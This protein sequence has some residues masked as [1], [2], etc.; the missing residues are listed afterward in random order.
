MKA[1]IVTKR[2]IECPGCGNPDRFS[3]EHLFDGAT[4]QFHRWP[5]GLDGCTAEV[6]G[7][8]HPNGSVE[9]E[10]VMNPARAPGFA[11]VKLRDLYLVLEEPHGR[12]EADHADYFYH[13]HQ[14]PTS[15]LKNVVEV[16]GPSGEADVH[17]MIRY[18]AGVADTEETRNALGVDGHGVSLRKVLEVFSTDGEPAPTSWPEVDEGVIPMIAEARRARRDKS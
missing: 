12:I 6:S 13:S 8:V 2:Y 17:G 15:L 14:C 4:R 10:H 1:K 7:T 16:Y 3:I 11:L 9:I 18:I 5:C